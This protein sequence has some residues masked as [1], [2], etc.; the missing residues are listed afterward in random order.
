MKH[1]VSSD[2]TPVRA[3]KRAVD[4]LR[5]IGAADEGARLT[6]IAA[7]AGLHKTTALRVLQTLV[8]EEFVGYDSQEQIY[9]IGPALLAVAMRGRLARD[10]RTVQ[11]LERLAM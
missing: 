7:A 3:I 5:A 10:L 8:A 1:K 4:V 6:D 11:A 2:E 9:S